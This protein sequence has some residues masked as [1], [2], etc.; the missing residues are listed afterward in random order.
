MLNYMIKKYCEGKD[1][2]ETEKI[3]DEYI[4]SLKKFFQVMPPLHGDND[5]LNK[6]TS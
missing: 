6:I 5:I 3:Y 1:L 2:E 4:I